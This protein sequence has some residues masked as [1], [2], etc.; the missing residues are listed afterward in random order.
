MYACYLIPHV[1]S[2]SLSL[3]LTLP[4]NCLYQHHQPTSA[5]TTTIIIIC[6]SSIFTWHNDISLHLLFLFL[7]TQYGLSYRYRS[8]RYTSLLPLLLFFLSLAAIFV[9][10]MTS[11]SDYVDDWQGEGAQWQWRWKKEEREDNAA[12]WRYDGKMKEDEKQSELGCP[13]LVPGWR[14]WVWY[15]LDTHPPLSSLSWLAIPQRYKWAPVYIIVE[16]W[17]EI[18]L[19]V[20]TWGFIVSLPSF[21]H[22]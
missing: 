9:L 5:T 3:S 14:W 19:I 18:I 1:Q 10:T 22:I 15:T 8:Y 6:S 4:I 7:L 20:K 12:C 13:R 17:C 11:H 16:L 2:L 21:L